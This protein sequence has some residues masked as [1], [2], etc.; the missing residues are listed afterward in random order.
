MPAE[1][2]VRRT[3]AVQRGA[4]HVASLLDAQQELVLTSAGVATP[5]TSSE[6]SKDVAAFG[7]WLGY[8]IRKTAAS[9]SEPSTPSTT[10]PSTDTPDIED[11]AATT[12]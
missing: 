4:A 6:T 1:K 7:R 2:G 11:A 9:T 5:P 12:A 8:M 10:M 3:L